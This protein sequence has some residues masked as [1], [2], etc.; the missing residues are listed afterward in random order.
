AWCASACKDSS[1]ARLHQDAG[2]RQRFCGARLHAPA[3]WAE[4]RAVKANCRSP[5][6]RGLRPDSG[7][8]TAARRGRRLSL[9]H[10]Q[11]RRR[12]GG[13]VRQRRT[14]RRKFVHGRGLTTKPEISGETL[15]GLIR[16]KLEAHRE[17]RVA[18]ARLMSAAAE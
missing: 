13:A 18:M 10:L 3:V 7:G 4:Q 1:E 17:V 9:P 5:S 11:R 14:L 16:P 6:R 2:R 8:R 12:R 15:G